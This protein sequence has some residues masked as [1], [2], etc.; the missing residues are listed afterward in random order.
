[1][2]TAG[3]ENDEKEKENEESE[4]DVIAG[5]YV[6]VVEKFTDSLKLIRC[7]PFACLH[8]QKPKVLS[9]SRTH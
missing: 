1:M 9:R 4:E 2:P 8:R 5:N 6:D 7:K 3:P